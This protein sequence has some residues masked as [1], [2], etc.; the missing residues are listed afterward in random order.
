[1][2]F[3]GTKDTIVMDNKT[4]GDDDTTDSEIQ[5]EVEDTVQVQLKFFCVLLINATVLGSICG[6]NFKCWASYKITR[7]S[8]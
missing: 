2:E 7:F 3:Y 5:D 4:D 8:L 6:N 1:M